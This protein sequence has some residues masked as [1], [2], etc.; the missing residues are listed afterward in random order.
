MKLGLK[1]IE[2]FRP[3]L[4]ATTI[5][6][7]SYVYCNQLLKIAKDNFNI[8]IVAGGSMPTVVPQVV[9]E[10]PNIDYVVETEGEIAFIEL[11]EALKVS[12]EKN[13]VDV[14]K[15]P[16]L[17]YKQDGISKKTG[18]MKYINMD[19]IP[20]QRLEFWDDKHFQ[21]A[22]DGKLYTTGFLKHQE[23]VCINVTIV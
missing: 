18:L 23:D 9:I 8:P 13:K 6:E 7:D 1:T 14:S 3:D 4:I 22:Y 11:L 19:D 2:N 5:V 20:N 12:R 10:N 21:K 15:V 16:N 17:W